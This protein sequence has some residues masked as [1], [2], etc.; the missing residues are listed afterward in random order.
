MTIRWAPM[1]AT[2]T[3][4]EPVGAGRN[5]AHAVRTAS[6][7]P[8]AGAV[9]GR[10]GVAGLEGLA[11]PVDRLA[12]TRG[13]FG[14]CEVAVQRDDVIEGAGGGRSGGRAGDRRVAGHALRLPE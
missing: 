6:R 12:Q 1:R 5:M 7:T 13:E 2:P 9:S 3:I 4:S 10:V 8:G 11:V 14:G